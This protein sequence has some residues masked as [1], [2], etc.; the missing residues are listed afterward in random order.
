M[1][2]NNNIRNAGLE[3]NITVPSSGGRR[4]DTL[5]FTAKLRLSEKH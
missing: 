5:S 2:T 1:K 3:K 4:L